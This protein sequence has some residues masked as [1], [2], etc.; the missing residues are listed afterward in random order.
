MRIPRI[1]P[2]T[3]LL[4]VSTVLIVIASVWA[5]Q[6]VGWLMPAEA[7]K[8]AGQ[9]DGLFRFMLI[10]ATGIFLGVQ[11]VLLYSAFVFK[12]AKD[13]MGDGPNMHGNLRLEILWTAIPTALVLYLSIYS[14]EVFQLLGAGS[15]MGGGAHHEDSGL[16]IRFQATNPDP[17]APPPLVIGVEAVQYAWIF[18]YPGSDT[19]V[20]E[21]HLPIGQPVRMDMKSNDVI[22][23]FWV[24]E[25]RLK[26]DVIPGRTTQVSFTPTKAGKYQLR[27]AELCGAYHGGMVVD[28]IVEDKK[29]VD[30]WLKSQA[31]LGTSTRVAQLA[32][33]A[34]AYG[35]TS[36]TTVLQSEQTRALVGHLRAQG[37]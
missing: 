29:D 36:G 16:P 9:I 4:V 5:G 15:P 27:C 35:A 37:Q 17:S 7:S 14:F 23:A 1:T 22:H 33:P 34:A 11:G 32:D 20:S 31:S 12:R 10:I 26:Q 25:F 19:Q 13:D 24:P 18:S 30:A 3:S 28:V 8:E 2:N 21:L 6:T